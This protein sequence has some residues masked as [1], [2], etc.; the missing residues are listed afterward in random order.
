MQPI[1]HNFYNTQPITHNGKTCYKVDCTNCEKCI[2]DDDYMEN[3]KENNLEK[4]T[5]CNKCSCSICKETDCSH[6]TL[7]NWYCNSKNVKRII[8][9]SVLSTAEI[10]IPSWCPMGLYN[11]KSTIS[12]TETT[13]QETKKE[14][15]WMEKKNMWES[16]KPICEWDNIKINEVYHVPPVLSEKRKDIIVTSKTDFS[17]QYRHLSATKTEQNACIYTVYKTACWW[18]FMSKHKLKKIE[19]VK[20]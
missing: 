9:M 15:T 7:N 4:I 17:F 10:S 3:K 11:K 20:S 13:R 18:K 16:I 6:G 19:L 14:L 1:T 8:E 5:S 12:T 2:F